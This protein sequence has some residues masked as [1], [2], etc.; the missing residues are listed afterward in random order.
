MADS[1]LDVY[2]GSEIQVEIGEYD[3]G[4]GSWNYSLV[5]YRRGFTIDRPNNQR[6]VYD[7]L[8]F[9]GNK[10]T[11][12]ENELSI[13]QEFRGFDEGLKLF[14]ERNALLVK[15]TIV[16]HDGTTPADPV[17]YY[18]N[19]STNPLEL[20]DI[21]D[22]GEFNATLTGKFTNEVTEEPADNSF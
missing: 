9:K 11:R 4:S 19:W 17:R 2:D 12:A 3:D 6:A 14:E 5:G 21:P 10:K 8:D 7:G 18:T 13:T 16:P 22:E 15:V 1:F 20:D